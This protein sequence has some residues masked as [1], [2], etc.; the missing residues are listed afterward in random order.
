[1]RSPA[2]ALFLAFTAFGSAASFAGS[3]GEPLD[4]PKALLKMV[5]ALE[6]SGDGRFTSSKSTEGGKVSSYHLRSVDYLGAVEHGQEKFLIAAAHYIRSSPAGQETPVARGHSY[7]V[8]FRPDYSIAAAAYEGI[9]DCYM[10]GNRLCR[11]EEVVIDFDD[12]TP[13]VRHV[14]YMMEGGQSLPY[15]FADR[16]TDEQWEDEE[17]MKREIEAEKNSK[18]S[19]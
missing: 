8:I 15:F 18:P 6:K 12:R 14:G 17:F 11:G 16:I 13:A 4:E 10:E 1:M 7:V 9:S 3:W 5:E 2:L 19:Q